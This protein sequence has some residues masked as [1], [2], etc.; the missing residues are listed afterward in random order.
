MKEFIKEMKR[1][2]K[3]KI[4]E[5]TNT[6]K[7]CTLNLLIVNLEKQ[8]NRLKVIDFSKIEKNLGMLQKLNHN[9]FYT[10]DLIN[11]DNIKRKLIHIANY[12]YFLFERLNNEG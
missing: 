1:I 7:Y 12:S 10:K 11:I 9:E 3:D 8:I 4:R 6:W 5:Y 2:Q